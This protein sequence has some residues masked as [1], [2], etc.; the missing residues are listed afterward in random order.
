MTTLSARGWRWAIALMLALLLAVA[1]LP[2]PALGDSRRGGRRCVDGSPSTA[3][4]ALRR[5]GVRAPVR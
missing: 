5:R 4:G 2:P 3:S 1:G